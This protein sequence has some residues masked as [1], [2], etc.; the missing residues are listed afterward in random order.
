MS[1]PEN[2]T[3]LCHCGSCEDALDAAAR[4]IEQLLEHQCFHWL[5]AIVYLQM[6]AMNGILMYDEEAQ[7]RIERVHEWAEEHAEEIAARFQQAIDKGG[8]GAG[9][10]N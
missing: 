3:P 1:N 6:T 9:R 4:G 5:I 2:H 10:L 7:E 8:H